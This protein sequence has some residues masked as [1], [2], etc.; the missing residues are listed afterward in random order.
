MEN[1]WRGK[2]WKLEADM[3]EGRKWKATGEGNF[4]NLRLDMNEGRKWKATGEGNFGNLR[5]VSY[6]HLTLPTRRTV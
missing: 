2:L 6:T 1:D 5:P 3:N 4:G